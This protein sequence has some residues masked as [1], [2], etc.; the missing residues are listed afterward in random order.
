ME[1]VYVIVITIVLLIIMYIIDYK[2]THHTP[3]RT[4][5]SACKHCIAVYEGGIHIDCDCE[6]MIETVW[7]FG[8][9]D[10]CKHFNNKKH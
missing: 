6:E 9:P 2:I 5:C 8:K 4:S 1:I 7:A 3:R 10:Y